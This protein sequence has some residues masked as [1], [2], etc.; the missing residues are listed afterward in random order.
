M[1]IAKVVI[2]HPLRHL[3]MAFSYLS[4]EFVADG[5]RVHVPFGKQKLVGYVQA[6]EKTDLDQKSL[7]QR[8]GFTYR[9]ISDVI[10]EK[11]ILTD[12]LRELASTL[13]N[14]TFTPLISCLKTMLP[15]SLK[16]SSSAKAT[17]KILKY[18]VY[19]ATPDKL[20]PKQASCLNE[21][22]EN[23][24]L[25]IKSFESS[26]IKALQKKGAVDIITKVLNREVE[27]LSQVSLEVPKL[28]QSQI[29]VLKGLFTLDKKKPFLLHGV[30]GSGKTE[31]YLHA[32]KHMIDMGK[33]VLML[34]PEIS[35]T[36]KMTAL[37][38]MRFGKNVAILHSRLSDG[39]RQD[40]YQR[41]LK[42]EVQIVV[43]ARSAVFAP[44]QHIGLIILDEEHDQSYKQN[45]T[46]RYHTKDITLWRAKY[47]QALVLLGS[48]SPSIE[49]YAKAQAGMYHLLEMPSRA[50]KQALPKCQIVDMGQEAKQGNLSMFSKAFV[51]A[52]NHCLSQGKQ[53]LILVNR[54]GYATYLLCKN[55]GY[56]PKCPHC[57]VSL[58]YHKKDR[59]LRCHYC[60]YEEAYQPK[61][62]ECQSDLLGY[63]GT[64]TEQMEELIQK[65]FPLAKVIRFD[66]DTTKNK[67]GHEKLLDAF[68]R[69]EGNILLGTQM[70]AKGLDFKDVNFVG[71]LDGDSA[72]NI[73]D[74][75][76]A[77]RTFQLLLQVAGRSGRHQKGEVVIQTYNPTHY[78]IVYAAKQDYQSFYNMELK[79]RQLGMYPP[80]CY[81]TSVLL[82]GKD[83]LA[84]ER[85][86]EGVANFLNGKLKNVNIL[87]PARAVIS[88]IDNEYRYRILI[89]YK[90]S[91][92]L[93]KLLKEALNHYQ[94]KVK[95]E[96]DVNPYVQL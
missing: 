32:A 75:R 86:A 85:C 77:E 6:V 16:P 52:L 41:I 43:G 66:M 22:K 58:T 15:P 83:E 29:E 64:G 8:D 59:V 70:I 39:Q 38:Q 81:L 36:P 95:I 45:N 63:R 62:Q 88:R 91:Q 61:C 7:S 2:E 26:I 65:E 67:Q 71:V 94:G 78:A 24:E 3:D 5:V 55:C 34:V 89:K 1:Y 54:R 17:T 31:V 49:S 14:M 20:T 80:Y 76:S 13:S 23:K 46:P 47:H 25:P 48:A 92:P 10:D 84:V 33:Q 35:L 4:E 69:H 74:F 90:Q 21:I 9:M 37:F 27:V 51:N 42:Q 72:L 12:E 28:N 93:F 50:T 44:L 82:S 68:E 53:A 57:D 19:K 87:G 79:T 40:E 56:V 60:G 18:A 11:P 30:T 73:P 96:V